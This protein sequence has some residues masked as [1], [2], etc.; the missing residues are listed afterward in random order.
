M[1]HLKNREIFNILDRRNIGCENFVDK[2]VNGK[3]YIIFN[4]SVM[5]FDHGDAEQE[6]W[7]IRKGC[8]IFDI[9]PNRKFRIIGPD[10]SALL[11]CLL[12]RAVSSV[13]PMKIAYGLICNSEGYVRDD[14]IVYK[15]S[16]NEYIVTPALSDLSLFAHIRDHFKCPD[17]EII[18]C[19][20]DISGFAVQGPAS[21]IVLEACGVAGLSAIRP[22]EILEVK[23]SRGSC[24]I[25]RIGFTGDLGYECWVSPSIANW[26]AEEI[27]AQGRCLGVDVLGYGL[28][29]VETCR[30]ESG[31]IIPGRDFSTDLAHRPGLDRRPADIGLGR[32]V[33]L[34]RKDF[35]GRDALIGNS[36]VNPEYVMRSFTS[37][38][39]ERF[40]NGSELFIKNGN[41][42]VHVGNCTS[43]T[44]SWGSGQT[45]GFVSLKAKYAEVEKVF[46]HLDCDIVELHLTDS[47]LLNLARKLRTPPEAYAAIAV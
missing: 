27:I 37:P 5:P 16:D 9:S 32:L 23:L 12:T 17:V 4:G 29:A 44:W 2:Y 31:M 38:I 6:Y 19:S 14:A 22:F 13:L 25:G 3:D 43:S 7:S 40:S 45:I 34:N 21:A 11:D 10:A 18:D 36:N 30:I 35:L 20:Q 24:V 41:Q 1:G 47:P 42:I 15:L 33:N 8:G 26:F 46:V 39:Q 28:T